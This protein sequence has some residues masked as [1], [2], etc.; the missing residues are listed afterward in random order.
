MLRDFGGGWPLARPLDH[1]RIQTA[2]AGET[3]EDLSH[4]P[5]NR[6]PALFQ[7]SLDDGEPHAAPHHPFSVGCR[8]WIAR[9]GSRATSGW[10]TSAT[11]WRTTSTHA[12]LPR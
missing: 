1:R 12:L 2:A 3:V 10:V 8:R 11:R 7:P 9:R 4:S 5:P 6:P